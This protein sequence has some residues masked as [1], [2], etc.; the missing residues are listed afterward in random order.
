M[1]N[2]QVS[3]WTVYF[4]TVTLLYREICLMAGSTAHE[5]F[6]NN[7]RHAAEQRHQSPWEA[8]S[9]VPYKSGSFRHDSLMALRY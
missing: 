9:T 1:N 7:E 3:S 5:L 6:A 2:E 4:S 8:A